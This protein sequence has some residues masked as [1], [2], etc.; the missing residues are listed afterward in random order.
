MTRRRPLTYSTG[1]IYLP[2]GGMSKE[3][4]GTDTLIYNKFS[5]KKPG[6]FSCGT[7]SAPR[8][9]GRV[10]RNL[11]QVMGKCEPLTFSKSQMT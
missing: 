6:A 9:Q 2:F 7:P 3:Q 10:C 11:I 4:F 5:F 1:I 8:C